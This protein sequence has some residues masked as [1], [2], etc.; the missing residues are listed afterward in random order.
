MP[1]LQYVGAGFREQPPEIYHDREAVEQR[2][3]ELLTTHYDREVAAGM[4]LWGTH[5]DDMEMTINTHPARLFASQGQQRSLALA[6][7]LAEGEICCR[8][9]GDYP[10]FLLDDVFSELDATR[11]GYLCEKISGKQIVI[12]S[13]EPD[14]MS[15][16]KKI[17]V[18][19]G[20]FSEEG[21]RWGVAPN[22]T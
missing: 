1:D 16:A 11:R 6:L 18:C 17:E 10:V 2:Y 21:T 4:T 19:G 20:E 8:E 14:L 9:T 15:G 13:C 12:T 3:L 5:R 7:K 22:P